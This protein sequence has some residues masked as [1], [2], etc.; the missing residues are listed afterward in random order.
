MTEKEKLKGLAI[1]VNEFLSG[2]I[3]IHDVI[4]REAESFLSVI[5]NIF[6]QGVPMS[7][8]L[9]YAKSLIPKSEA[10]KAG[11]VSFKLNSYAKLTNDE[12]Y[13]FEMLFNYYTSLEKTVNCLVQKQVLMDIKSNDPL[14]KISLEEFK[15][16]D[17]EYKSLINQYLTIGDQLNSSSHI[18]FR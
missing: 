12:K 16:K 10:V 7:K 6:G 18:I 13:Y 2:Y 4:H 14:N 9:D 8:L 11:L 17:N 1:D 15:I 5:K 3:K